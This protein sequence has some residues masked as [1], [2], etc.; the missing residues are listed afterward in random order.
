[1]HMEVEVISFIYDSWQLI[2]DAR[3]Y[4]SHIL[5]SALFETSRID[6]QPAYVSFRVRACRESVE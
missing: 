2:A 4:S 3:L 6:R 1:M 5:M